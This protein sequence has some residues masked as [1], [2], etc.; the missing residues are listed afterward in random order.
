MKRFT[1]I[2]STGACFL[3]VAVTLLMF[4]FKNSDSV[5]EYEKSSSSCLNSIV[6]ETKSVSRHY[7]QNP[8]GRKSSKRELLDDIMG[9]PKTSTTK[10]SVCLDNTGRGQVEIQYLDEGLTNLT[11]RKNGQDDGYV[12]ASVVRISDSSVEMYDKRGKLVGQQDARKTGQAE[13]LAELSSI[14]TENKTRKGS[15]KDALSRNGDKI[16]AIGRD[17]FM[18][19]SFDRETGEKTKVVYE[20]ETERPLVSITVDNR[21]KKVRESHYCYG[22][23]NNTKLPEKVSTKEYYTSSA[24]GR[25]MVMETFEQN[26]ILEYR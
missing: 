7:P 20:N 19:V 24:T 8:T 1:K 3:F 5:N 17:L 18:A 15:I 4:S 11:V 13:V 6:F 25:D 12:K 14:L 10:T 2:A 9:T 16:I 21:G 22:G 26:T 23:K